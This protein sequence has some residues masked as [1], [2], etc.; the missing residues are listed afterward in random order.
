MP[1][2]PVYPFDDERD[3]AD[4]ERGSSPH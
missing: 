3:V 4:A 1:R 2:D